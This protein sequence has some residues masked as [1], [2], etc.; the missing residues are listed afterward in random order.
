MISPEFS[1][2][3]SA[4]MHPPQLYGHD[5]GRCPVHCCGCICLALARRWQTGLRA[6]D[7]AALERKQKAMEWSGIF[8][9]DSESAATMQSACSDRDWDKSPSGRSN[10]S[11]CGRS[12]ELQPMPTHQA[13]SRP[14]QLH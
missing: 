6:S 4:A 2:S 3:D 12:L 11:R 1:D 8:N 5:E 10:A 14:T 13:A 7:L 9:A